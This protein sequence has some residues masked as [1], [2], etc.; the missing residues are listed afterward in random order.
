MAP[1]RFTIKD[2][3]KQNPTPDLVAGDDI[4]SHWRRLI[5][6]AARGKLK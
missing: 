5:V 3:I 4:I 1:Q 6:L 2:Q